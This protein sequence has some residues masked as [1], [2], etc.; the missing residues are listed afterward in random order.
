MRAEMSVEIQ[1]FLFREVLS[2]YRNQIVLSFFF[3]EVYNTI[4]FQ[5]RD[6]HVILNDSASQ[7]RD[8]LIEMQRNINHMASEAGVILGVVENI[9]RSIA[10]TDEATLQTI[11]GTFTDAQTRMIS[12]LEEIL[13]L[14]TDMPLTPPESLGSLALRLSERYCFSIDIDFSVSI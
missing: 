4:S 1:R 10:L 7:L 14:A 5:A 9:S 12:A 11:T 8:A 2:I 6:L 13:R 3:R